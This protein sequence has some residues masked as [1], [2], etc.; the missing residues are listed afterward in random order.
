[1]AV[2]IPAVF[3]PAGRQ[4]RAASSPGNSGGALMD[5]TRQG[6]RHHEAYMPPQA[7]VS[8][9]FAIPPAR[10]RVRSFTVPERRPN[11]G[12]PEAHVVTGLPTTEGVLNSRSRAESHTPFGVTWFWTRHD[13]S[14]P[15]HR[16]LVS[17]RPS[18]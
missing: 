10:I 1:M 9:G 11:P 2:F 8:L 18:A 14:R 17:I 13:R 5:G 6:Y 7:A 16:G 12:N 15:P 3:I 4:W